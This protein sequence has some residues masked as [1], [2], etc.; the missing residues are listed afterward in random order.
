[1]DK[2]QE[3]TQITE[4]LFKTNDLA[5]EKQYAFIKQVILVA[6]GSLSVII[7]LKKNNAPNCYFNIAIIA[8]GLGI[9]ASS[10]AL[11]GEVSLLREARKKLR[12][13]QL[14][15]RQGNE[16]DERIDELASHKIYDICE[17]TGYISLMLSV[18]FLIGYAITS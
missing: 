1:M 12:A 14:K 18:P 13:A 7:S 15:L 11:Y 16:P 2:E 3:L 8:I 9:L 5:N 10:I 6:S 4:E 17:Y